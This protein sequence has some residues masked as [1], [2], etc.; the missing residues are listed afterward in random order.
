MPQHPPAPP[1]PLQPQALRPLAGLRVLEFCH[2]IAG[3]FAGQQLLQLGAEVIKVEPPGGQDLLAGLPHAQRAFAALNAGKQVQTIDLA[4]PEGLQQ[5]LALVDTADVLLDSYAP[6]SL[7]RKGLDHATLAARRPGLVWCSISGYGS[8]DPAWGAR[9][10]YDH[11]VQ[12]MSGMAW[13]NGSTGDPPIK[14]GFPLTDTATASSAVN[15]IL[16]ALMARERSGQGAYLEISMARCAMQLLFPMACDTALT[17]NDPPR[18]G[19]TG[20][21]FSPGAGFFQASDGWLALGA[22]TSDQLQRALALLRPEGTDG[23]PPTEAL[24]QGF[25]RRTAVQAED[26][27]VAAGVPVARLRGLGEFIREAV[28]AGWL[29]DGQDDA[30]RWAAA[31]A[32]GWRGFGVADA[33]G[34]GAVAQ[35]AG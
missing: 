13:I 25:A 35:D 21:S 19:N 22:N 27:L 9:G 20:Y 34:P 5:A 15:A 30:G 29:A 24:A 6:G 11:V 14:V 3:P 17:G 31:F 1:P 2:V 7:A 28:A 16:A 23:Q 12:A 33:A 4:T 18:I 8:E 10:A 26:E 32:L